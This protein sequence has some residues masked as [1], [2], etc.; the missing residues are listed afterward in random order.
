[1]QRCATPLLLAVAFLAAPTGH[2]GLYEQ[3]YRGLGYV[4]LPT[5]GP[6]FTTANGTVVN[7]SRSGRLQIVPNRAGDGHRLEFNRTFGPDTTG[8]P[9]IIDL[10]PF[11]VELA[12]AMALTADYTRR[13]D[14]LIADAQLAMNNLNYRLAV[15]TGGADATLVGVFDLAHTI[16]V[17][18]LG[19]YTTTL[20]VSNNNSLLVVD[21]LSDQERTELD[22]DIGPISARGNIFL[23]LVTGGL[24]ALGAGGVFED[25]TNR[26]LVS[27][28]DEALRDAFEDQIAIA[29]YQVVGE[30]DGALLIE[31]LDGEPVDVDA[32]QAVLDAQAESDGAAIPEPSAM[33]GLLLAGG[34]LICMRRR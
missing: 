33:L 6:T 24:N 20:D 21:T 8:R 2:A 29:G 16:E 12:G 23:D 3:I 25:I 15:K 32:L 18:Q 14:L 19:F 13:F 9:E 30:E 10:G 4:A 1:M 7:G 27:Q 28:L 5:G 34:G 26:S 17:N 31:T 11:E 22:F